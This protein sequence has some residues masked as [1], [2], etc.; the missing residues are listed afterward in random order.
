MQRGAAAYP[1]SAVLLAITIVLAFVVLPSPLGLIAVVVAAVVEVGEIVAWKRW[2]S[3]YK[4]QAGAEALVGMP[5]EVIE[6]CAPRGRVRLR[7]EIWNARSS[8]PLAAG[9]TATVAAVDGLVLDLRPAAEPG[10]T[11]AGSESVI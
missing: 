9:S 6:A 1:P 4:I 7:G 11:V 10:A 2:L 5:V 3:R 8:T